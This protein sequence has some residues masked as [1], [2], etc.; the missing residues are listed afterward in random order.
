MRV[1]LLQHLPW[2]LA[3][4]G[5]NFCTLFRS[6]LLQ[7]GLPRP[8]PPCS[9]YWFTVAQPDVVCAEKSINAGG[10]LHA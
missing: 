4:L 10:A 6:T 2:M 9:A 5:W 3:L 8:F 7:R 1:V